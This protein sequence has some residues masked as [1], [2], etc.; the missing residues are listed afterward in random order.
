MDE[1]LSHMNQYGDDA[2]LL[3]GGTDLIPRLKMGLTKPH[4]IVSLSAI[5]GLSSIRQTAQTIRIGALTTIYQLQRNPI[6]Y[7]CYPALY[8]AAVSI[9]G[10]SIRHTATVGGNL[11]QD[12][13]CMAYNQSK[14]WR[15]SFNPCLKQGGHICN[16]VKGG[17]RCFAAYCGD[18]APAFISLGGLACLISKEGEREIPLE[19]LFAGDGRSPFSMRRGE[20]LKEVIL[21]YSKTKGGY[22]KLRIRNTIDYPLASVALSS[23]QKEKGRLVVGAV[24]PCPLTYEFSS[25]RQ[26]KLLTEKIDKDTIPIANRPLSP[27]YRKQMVK[28]LAEELIKNLGNSPS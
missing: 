11:I 14:E 13:R 8:E 27:L 28:V 2:A 25:Y 16:A 10:E 5:N 4:V 17:R 15:A 21:L 1:L 6:I 9:G 18:L 7:T 23:D 12:T 3:A 22:N 19:A 24:G 26:L 20:L